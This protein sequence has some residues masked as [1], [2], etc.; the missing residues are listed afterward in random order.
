MYKVKQM[1]PKVLPPE[2]RMA[3][4]VHCRSAESECSRSERLIAASRSLVEDSNEAAQRMQQ[5]ASKKLEQRL[6]VVRFWKQELNQKLGE[7][8]E[9]VEVLTT[10]KTRLEKALE[11]CSDPLKIIMQCLSERENHVGI[12]RV[13]DQLERELMK[14]KEVL[15]GVISLLQ[16]TLEQTNEQLRLNRSAKYSLEK[17][18]QRKFEAE[19][20]DDRCSVLTNASPGQ[21]HTDGM[22]WPAPSAHVTPD[23]W[24]RCTEANI[25]QAERQRIS[26]TSLRALIDRVLSQTASDMRSQHQATSAALQLRIQETK[27]AKEQLEDRLNEVQVEIANQERSIESLAVAI[28]A[29]QGP[30]TVAQKRLALRGQRPDIELCLDTAQIQLSAELQDLTAHV[31]RLEV[32]LSDSE[33]ELKALTQNQLSLEEQI[34][35]K[36]NSLYID[37]V[38]CASLHQSIAIHSF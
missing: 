31:E 20:I 3:N 1:A 18:L 7:M 37:E 27:D 38:I 11:N 4:E 2:W 34:Q 30:L 25:S 14:E 23:G 33:M 21:S 6:Q 24:E 36:S 10:F 9:E 29:K 35:G 15:E 8:C 17:D 13:H 5:D 12:D 16:R 26:S 28:Q 22:D 19:Q 32:S